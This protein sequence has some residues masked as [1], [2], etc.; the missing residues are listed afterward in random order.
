MSPIDLTVDVLRGS[1]L[2]LPKEGSKDDRGR[3]LVVAGS[4]E[5]PGAALL[6]ATATLRAARA[7]SNRDR[8]ERRPAPGPGDPRGH[9]H[10]YRG[11]SGGGD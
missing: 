8:Q 11:S 7:T 1:P 3:V 4:V 9:G 6:A 10:R 5:V 2:P